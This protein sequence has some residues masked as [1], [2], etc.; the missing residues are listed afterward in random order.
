MADDGRAVS[1]ARASIGGHP[2]VVATWDFAVRGGS[3]GEADA[4][5][6]CDAVD[7]AVRRRLPLVTRLRSGGTRLT[8]GMHALV[9]IPRALL[10]LEELH[11]AGLP[12]VCVVDTPATGG[13]WLAVGCTA[14]I[15]IGVREGVVGFSGPRVVEAM[16]GR[17]PTNAGTAQA[18][19][20]AGLLDRQVDS[21]A[22]V[23][24]VTEALDVLA[25][26]DPAGVR[27][28]GARPP[29]AVDGW[30]QV[31]TS[32]TVDRPTGADLLASI[33]SPSIPLGA[34]DPAVTAAVGRAHGRRVVG[35]ALAATRGAMPGPG[36]FR[37][38]SRA[39]G[40][41]GA[42]D[43][44]LLVLVDTPGADPHTEIAGLSPAI[45]TA[46]AAVLACRA[47]TLSLVHGEG[48]SGG[49]LAGAVTDVVGVGPHGWFAALGPE[50]AAAALRCE[51]AEAARLMRVTPAD[52][53]AS[54]FADDHVPAGS[55]AQWLAAGLDRLRAAPASVRL[56]RRRRRWSS[57]LRG[58]GA[59]NG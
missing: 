53:L 4:A 31:V 6:L 52:L 27:S 57:P 36:G 42:L 48:G 29:T 51:P 26:D 10:A 41:A 49:A 54:G 16:T 13:V 45:A 20:G 21:T 15:R 58:E 50:G 2:A 3:F 34:S 40:L 38:L 56:E 18:A 35:V 22:A 24:A 28:S 46:M 11:A 39:A 55:E 25:A 44:G 12:H 5:T 8:E 1:A 9:G 23:G 17:A 43:L 14:D 47:P 32:R 30:H 59:P 33:L 37:L 7:D 19:Y